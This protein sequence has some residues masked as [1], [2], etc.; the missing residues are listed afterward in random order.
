M[1]SAKEIDYF[2]YG[3]KTTCYILVGK[4]GAVK[5]MNHNTAEM[6]AAYHSALSGE[7]RI[8]AVWPGNYRS[9]LFVVDDLN[10]FADAFGIRRPDTHVHDIQWHLDEFDDGV[11]R[12]AHVAVRFCCGCSLEKLGIRKFANDMYEQKGWDV[13]VSKGYSTHYD[14]AVTEYT[15]PVKR[16]SLK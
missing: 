4:D 11:S 15:I 9:D 13:A 14:G 12:S 5:Q 3:A 8:Y 2:P 6:T 10:A 16:S 7:Y 1:R